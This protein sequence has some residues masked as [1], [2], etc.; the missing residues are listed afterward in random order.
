MG[1]V[2]GGEGGEGGEDGEEGL[3]LVSGLLGIED[4]NSNTIH[5]FRTKLF[6]FII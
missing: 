5:S 3:G 1:W 4:L 2:L 6:K